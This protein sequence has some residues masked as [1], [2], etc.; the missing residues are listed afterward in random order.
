MKKFKIL[1]LSAEAAPFAKV[2]GLADVAGSLPAELAKKGCDIKMMLPLYGCIDRKKFGLKKIYAKLEVPS[3]MLMINVNIWKGIL[4]G[5]KV[6][7]FFID[8]PEYF[9]GQDIYDKVNNSERFLFFSLA[10]LYCLPII[11]FI[12]DIVHCHD[13]HVALVPDIIKSSNLEYLSN[14]KTL[15]TIHNFQYQGKTEV[16]TLKTGNLHKNMLAVLSRD[17]HNGDINFM[18]Q[19]V[20]GADIINTVS[21]TYAKEITTSMYGAGLDRVLRLRKNDVY[22]ILNGIDKDFYDPA[23]DKYIKKNYTLAGIKNGKKINK[24]YLQEK[25]GLAVDENRSIA[26]VISRLVWQKG[27]EL[28]NEKVM[29]MNCQF[30]FLG[31]GRPEYEK[32]LLKIGRKY[33][34]KVSVNIGFDQALAQQIYAGADI[35]LMPSRFEPCGLGQM[36]AMRYG[37]VPVVRDTGG[38]ADTV[39]SQTGFKFK[40]FSAEAMSKTLSKALRVYYD[41]SNKWTDMQKTC[42]K[43]DF[44]W[45]KPAGE[46]MEL[47]RKLLK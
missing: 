37:T 13:S 9:G 32:L 30:V 24:K 34:G 27:L 39:N 15:F 46:Y 12:P 40:D 14:I 26:A 10:S 1:S 21:K 5:S 36:M 33:P 6:E 7:V 44:S 47:Y 35:F 23:K 28:F 31:S 38:L 45:K 29:D 4:P 41:N 11:K 8:A 42:M 17:A 2:G 19:G 16:G 20:L 25:L 3:G 22:G 18:V 43:K